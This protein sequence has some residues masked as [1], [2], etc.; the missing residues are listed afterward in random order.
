MHHTYLHLQLIQDPAKKSGYA[1]G[2]AVL[3]CMGNCYIKVI[4]LTAGALYDWFETVSRLMVCFS[5]W[6][7]RHS[8]G[9]VLLEHGPIYVMV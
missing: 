2:T 7:D 5:G 6:S 3:N 8:W 4:L 9:G 1:W